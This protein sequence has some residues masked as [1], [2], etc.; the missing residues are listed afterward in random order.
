[1]PPAAAATGRKEADR[2][3]AARQEGRRPEKKAAGKK[4][5]GKKAAG[6]KAAKK[7]SAAKAPRVLRFEADPRALHGVVDDLG[8]LVDAPVRTAGFGD[9]APA[10]GQTASQAFRLL[11]PLDMVV[12]DVLGYDLELQSDGGPTLVPTTA[13]AR[14]EVRFSFQHVNEHAEPEQTAPPPVQPPPVQ[15][16]AANSSRLVYSV[17]LDERIPF[18]TSGVLAA[19]SRLPLLVVPLATPRPAAI[20]FVPTR[21][22]QFDTVVSA[23]P[24]GVV[25]ARTEEGLVITTTPTRTPAAVASPPRSAM[26][27]RAPPRSGSRATRSSP[28]PRSTSVGSALQWAASRRSYLGRSARSVRARVRSCR[29]HRAPTRP[30]SRRRTG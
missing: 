14:L 29:G 21:P 13:A 3:E 9:L 22:G 15:A 27:W 23:L 8:G 28:R 25:L 16:L 2:Q 7:A 26:C 17:A 19:M 1:M 12:L 18:S 10:E 20:R 11:R 4:A 5:A 24:K 30:R 6:K